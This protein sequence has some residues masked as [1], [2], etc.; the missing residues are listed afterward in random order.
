MNSYQKN[1]KVKKRVVTLKDGQKVLLRPLEVT[2]ESKLIKFLS[3]LSE[4]TRYFYIL[5]NY[6]KKAAEHLGRSLSNHEKKH[7]VI[8][9]S[10]KEIIALS[11]FSLDLPRKTEYALLNM[12]LN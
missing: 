5:D 4:D 8:E 9:N 10:E 6:G 2:D 12:E 3:S 1:Y 7:F 11:K